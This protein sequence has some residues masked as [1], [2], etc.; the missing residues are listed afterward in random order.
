VFLV[1]DPRSRRQ[2]ALRPGVPADE[3]HRISHAAAPL[4]GA[5]PGP[6]GG[7]GDVAHP[8]HEERPSRVGRAAGPCQLRRT[9]R[10]GPA[11]S[12]RDSNH[13]SC[14]CIAQPP[15]RSPPCR[16]SFASPPS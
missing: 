14:S 6:Q 7:A 9:A 11:R 2:V 10:E 4:G 13:H 8:V 1:R 16:S 15:H 3:V 12:R 5:H